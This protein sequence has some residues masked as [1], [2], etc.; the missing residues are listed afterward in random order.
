M[1]KYIFEQLN[2]DVCKTYLIASKNDAAIVDPKLDY[3]Q[4]YYNLLRERGLNLKYILETHT[5][6]DHL[7]GA[8]ALMDS[9][10]AVIIMHSSSPQKCSK[11]RVKEGDK[12]PLGDIE[13]EVVETPGHALDAISY[14]I[15]G[16]ILTGDALFLDEGGAGRDDLPNGS[17]AAHYETLVKL[18]SLSDDLVVYPAH[19]Y[20]DKDPS[21]L[22]E[23]KKTNP[24]LKFTTK[25]AFVDYLDGLKLG[26]ADWMGPVI[27]AN[28]GCTRDPDAAEIPEEG[29][30]CEV[31]GT[32]PPEV[33]SQKVGYISVEELK[34][35]IDSGNAPLMVDV[36]DAA[37][38]NGPD[39]KIDGVKNIPINS[40]DASLADLKEHKDK[41]VCFICKHGKRSHTAAQLAKVVGFKRPIVLD[42]GMIE[43]NKMMR[44]K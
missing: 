44:N 35:K 41:L 21:S 14:I 15:D 25:E 27:K 24:H 38:L 36:R 5:H 22:G 1:S 18:K 16:K 19:D 9:T 3:W 28:R 30:A 11:K 7:S 6:A 26:A 23:Q 43:W 12:L 37:D 32:L 31:K 13:I 2:T 10:G 40:V 4:A 20:R 8:A 34:K 42:G 33:A 17:P 29:H 39:G